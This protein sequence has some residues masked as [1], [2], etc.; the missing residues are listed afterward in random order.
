MVN[1]RKVALV[2]T[3]TL[4]LAGASLAA[5]SAISG[6]VK[7]EDGKPLKDAVIKITRTDIRGNYQVKTNKRGEYYYGGLPLGT[8]NVECEVNGAVVDRVNGIRTSLGD[9][10]VVDF[11][12]QASKQRRD[13]LAKAAATGQLTDAQKREL[14]PEQ[15][16]AIERQMKEQQ[17]AM[18]KNKA[19]NDAFNAGM[20]AMEAKQYDAAIENFKKAAEIDPKQHVVYAN[21]ADAYIQLSKTKTG[22]EQQAA[23]EGGLANW[24]KALELA[25]ENGGYHNNY[26]LALGTA[27]K[28]DEAQAELE[29]AA[30]LDP[31]Q[32]GKAFFNLGALYVNSGQLEPSGAAFKR[33]IEADPNYAEAYYQ[34]GVYLMGKATTTADGKIVPPEGTQGYFEKY[35]QLAPNG[36]NAEPAKAMIAT[37][38][39]TIQ[40]QYISPEEQKRQEAEA[41]KKQRRKK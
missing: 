12:L 4:L 14:S 8:Y 18:A 35:L 39:S 21:L 22:A 10:K 25:P 17:A 40:T 9:P 5:T 7:G 37:I 13:A 24:Q 28:F 38:Q 20:T 15:R 2:G 26:A 6:T 34:Y 31:S 29:K 33:A 16:E 30:Q 36:P 11:D 41:A 23:I 27:K 32:A 3:L 19:L 1:V